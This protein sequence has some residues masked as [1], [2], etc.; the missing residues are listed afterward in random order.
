MVCV[1]VLI[2]QLAHNIII[3][4]TQCCRRH[5]EAAKLLLPM[6]L[7]IHPQ[8]PSNIILMLHTGLRLGLC[9]THHA[10]I[11]STLFIVAQVKFKGYRVRWLVACGIGMT[12][13]APTCPTFVIHRVARFLIIAIHLLLRLNRMA[14]TVQ[15]ELISSL[16][17]DPATTLTHIGNHRVV[18]CAIGI[19]VRA[20][21]EVATTCT[22]HRGKELS[23]LVPC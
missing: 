22:S 3:I 14:G 2:A 20:G 17:R 6:L 21:C 13:S 10:P 1:M 4:R 9:T 19:V 16:G 18:E 12:D 11:V 8:L 15:Q 7:V 5:M 23:R